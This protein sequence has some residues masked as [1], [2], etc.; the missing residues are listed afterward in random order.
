[1]ATASGPA[2]PGFPITDTAGAVALFAP[3]LI[4]LPVEQL[5]AAY[6]DSSLSLLRLTCTG[7]LCHD[8]IE[9]PVRNVVREALAVDAR[10][11]LVAHNHPRGCPDPSPADRRAT[12]RLA[13]IGRALGIRLIDHLLFA[14]EE[15]VS[16]RALGLL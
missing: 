3:V 13:E 7:S 15:V 1:M 9:V 10:A 4:G 5:C 11:L 16:F 8:R 6:L 14:G 12:R 2:G